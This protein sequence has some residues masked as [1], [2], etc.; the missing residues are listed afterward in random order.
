MPQHFVERFDNLGGNAPSVLDVA[1]ELEVL[2]PEDASGQ[3][4]APGRNRGF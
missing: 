3:E 2:G 1:K 4:K